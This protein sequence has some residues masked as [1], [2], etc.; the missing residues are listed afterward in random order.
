MIERKTLS[1]LRVVRSV[2]NVVGGHDVPREPVV[3]EHGDQHRQPRE[4]L[5]HEQEAHKGKQSGE[6]A[7]T[8]PTRRAKLLLDGLLMWVL[9]APHHLARPDELTDV[10]KHG[11]PP[12]LNPISS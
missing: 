2:L 3:C 4:R 1:L 10:T 5:L 12:C 11:I 6:D 9:E 7:S 8:R